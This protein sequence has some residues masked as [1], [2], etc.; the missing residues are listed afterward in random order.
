[1]T[2]TIEDNCFVRCFI[3]VVTQIHKTHQG[4]FLTVKRLTDMVAKYL[5]SKML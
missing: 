3:T 1:M 4:I 2:F 5:G